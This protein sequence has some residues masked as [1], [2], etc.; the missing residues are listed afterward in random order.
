V[1]KLCFEH[2]IDYCSYHD[3][4]GAVSSQSTASS[5]RSVNKDYATLVAEQLQQASVTRQQ[6]VAPLL[7]T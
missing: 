5:V 2:Q 7:F 4:G 3:T 1:L 6:Q